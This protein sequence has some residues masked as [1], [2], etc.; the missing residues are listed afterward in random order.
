MRENRQKNNENG[1][2]QQ[3]QTI[4]K[5]K[6]EVEPKHKS[7]DTQRIYVLIR[8]ENKIKGLK[9]WQKPRNLNYVQTV[10]SLIPE[11]PKPAW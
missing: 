10:C 3:W 5:I 9:T 11:H 1:I 4:S 7:L 2:E 6:S 8:F